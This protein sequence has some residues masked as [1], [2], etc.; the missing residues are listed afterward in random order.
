MGYS[1]QRFLSRVDD[2][3]L[4]GIC[5]AV[6]K[7]AVVTPCG[8]SFCEHCLDTWLN[9]TER[10]T[11][12]E[13]RS[14]M[15]PHEARPVIALRSLISGLSIECLHRVR[16]CRMTLKLEDEQ[17]HQAECGYSPAQCSTCGDTMDRYRLANH[18]LQCSKVTAEKEEKGDADFLTR[19]K[20]SAS[21]RFDL[22]LSELACRVA[23]LEVQ[24]K[25]TRHELEMSRARNRRLERELQRRKS[26]LEAQKSEMRGT[27]GRCDTQ[28]T[29]FQSAS[30]LSQFISRYLLIKPHYV[31]KDHVF[32]SIRDY[33]DHYIAG[34][35][36]MYHND[37]HALVATAY[38]SNWFSPSQRLCIQQW[39]R[40][41]SRRS[42]EITGHRTNMPDI[43]PLT[44]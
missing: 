10:R 27:S 9:Q 23:T 30:Q 35:D 42:Q 1:L 32:R 21:G 13:C 17:R 34:G 24:L 18:E 40:T 31:N 4:C 41:L 5:A 37:V 7:D 12:P 14:G 22:A 15:L 28:L 29:T 38:A 44:S 20:N 6:L 43:L 39:L 36:G 3:L 19:R 8:H 25:Q 16:G 26:E 33:F 2:N 11:C